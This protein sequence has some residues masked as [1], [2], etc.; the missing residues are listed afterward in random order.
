MV[1][2]LDKHWKEILYAFSG[3]GPNLL[4][5]IMGAYFTDA[6]NPA[7]I[8]SDSLQVINGTCLILPAVFP[9][10]WMLAK[11]FDG[12]VDIPLAALTDSLATKWGKRRPPIAVGFLPMVI[13]FVMCWIPVGSQTFYTIWL[14]F[15]A[16]IFFTTYTMCLICLYGSFS[17]VC[18]SEKQRTR[19][20]SYKAFFDTI[21]YCIAYALVP[22][23]LSVMNVHIDKLVLMLV[24]LMFTMLIPLFMIKEGK[25]YGYPEREGLKEERVSIGKSLRLTFGNKLFRRWLIVNCCSFFGL[26]MFLVGMNALMIGGMGL[27]SWEMSVL[28]TLAFAPVP[29]MLYL[30]NKLKA[31]KGIRFSYQTC[32]IMFAV[33]ILSFDLASLYV[34]GGNRTVQFII[35][36]TGSICASWAIGSFF[37]VPYVIP[38]QIASVEEKTTGVNHAAM[39]FAAQALATTII[40]AIASAGVYENIK[41][42]FIDKPTGSVAYAL[43]AEEAA[44]KLGASAENVYNL[45]LLIVPIIVSVMCIAGFIAAFKL[46]RDFTAELV[47][48]EIKKMNPDADVSKA[49]EA[50][51]RDRESS[52]VNIALWILSFG[53][54]GFIWLAVILSKLRTVIGGKH[55]WAKWLLCSVIPFFGAF[56]MLSLHKKLSAAAKEK[57]VKIRSKALYVILAVIFPIMPVN[58]AGLAFLT[59]DTEKLIE[60]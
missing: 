45:G 58:I 40:G 50:D 3:F 56:Y 2:S 48:D 11:A 49:V 4:M 6:V 8:G 47:A 46:P 23:L 1:H 7:A 24:P 28:N 27:E 25:K 52:G 29:M 55:T 37:M 20:S 19:L 36:G 59:S 9:I 5:V 12:I 18:N 32:L 57:N 35:A 60:G 43:S 42:L 16:M 44:E 14:F 26:Q 33:A 41:L 53:L 21:S 30:F 15:W 54:F 34:T 17:T 38:S 22:L 39:Y 51:T 10:L 31:K 13:S